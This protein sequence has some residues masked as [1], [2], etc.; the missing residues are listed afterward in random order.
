MP[1]KVL[2]IV[3]GANRVPLKNG[4]YYETGFWLNE[5]AQPLRNMLDA[6]YGVDFASPDGKKPSIDPNSIKMLPE[7]AR[8][9]MCGLVKST[10]SLWAPRAFS[11]LSE[12]DLAQYTG[13]FIPGGHAPMVDLKDDR[14]LGRVL[15]HF[16]NNDKPTAAICHGPVALL[17]CSV[18]GAGW[19][20]SGYRMTCF[21]KLE[22]QMQEEITHVIPGP[23]PYY[24]SDALR[25]AGAIVK[26]SIFS[27]IPHTIRDRE[28]LTGQD[29]FAAEK[30]G[31]EFV[32]M[33]NEYLKPAIHAMNR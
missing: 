30:L 12:S 31:K 13:V 29:P 19:P 17:S 7:N 4:N 27:F 33:L 1:G 6:S 8:N 20:Y 22:E 18:A 28:L 2:I 5:L 26:N 9:E 10:S 14:D 21:S 24:I 25:S 16:H 15:E 32:G 3:S 11:S 23:L